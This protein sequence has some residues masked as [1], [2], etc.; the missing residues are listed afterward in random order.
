[1]YKEKDKELDLILDGLPKLSKRQYSTT[2]QLYYLSK[3][4]NKLG[5]YDADDFLKTNQFKAQLR[6]Y[7]K[8]GVNYL[9]HCDSAML[10]SQMGSGKVF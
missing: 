2:G 5:L 6:P 7:Q 9:F 8:V 10:A 3:I 1:M 4:A